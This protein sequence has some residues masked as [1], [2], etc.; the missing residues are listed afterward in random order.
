M[1]R[2]AALSEPIELPWAQEDFARQR[3]DD[4]RLLSRRSSEDSPEF[5]LRRFAREREKVKSSALLSRIDQ[6][7]RE[8]TSSQASDW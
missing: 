8:H 7:N 5:V 3:E 1:Q 2:Y 6:L 4:E